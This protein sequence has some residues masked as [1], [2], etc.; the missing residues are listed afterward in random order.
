MEKIINMNAQDFSISDVPIW[1]WILLSCILIAA[2]VYWRY[3]RKRYNF[4]IFNVPTMI[5]LAIL[6]GF[7]FY[8]YIDSIDKDVVFEMSKSSFH[9]I[10]SLTLILTIIGLYFYNLKKTNWYIAFLNTFLQI[11]A[12][13]IF[14]ILMI[15]KIVLKFLGSNSSSGTQSSSDNTVSSSNSLT[16]A[17]SMAVQKGGLVFVFD[18]KNRTLFTTPGILQGYTSSTVS[19]KK[20]SGWVFVCD[21]KGNTIS[22]HPSG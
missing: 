10:L 14:V 18:E 21:V 7:M 11:L 19:V 13:G 17:I 22:T 3:C 6:F 16:P 5:C 12:V 4:D 8:F 1:L 15:G 9:L 2:F 20:D